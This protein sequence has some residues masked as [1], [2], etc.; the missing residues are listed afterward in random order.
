MQLRI[1]FSYSHC[2]FTVEKR[3]FGKVLQPK[4]ISCFCEIGSI[5]FLYKAILHFRKNISL[6]DKTGNATFHGIF[7]GVDHLLFFCLKSNTIFTGKMTHGSFHDI[8]YQL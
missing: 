5:I 2:S 8:Q 3:F 6:E 7:S 4:V 1:K